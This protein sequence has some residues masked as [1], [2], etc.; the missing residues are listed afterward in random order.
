[1]RVS[2]VVSTEF[3]KLVVRQVLRQQEDVVLVDEAPD[4]EALTALS[5][6]DVLIIERGLF[7]EVR[8]RGGLVAAHHRGQVIIVGQGPSLVMP[9]GMVPGKI[10]LVPG[11]SE[12]QA[13]DP[14]LL[15]AR[16]LLALQSAGRGEAARSPRPALLD[17]PP[18]TDSPRRVRR[19]V[20][21]ALVGI[22][23]STGGPD[24]LQLLLGALDRPTCPLV[25][26][27]HIPSAHTASLCQHLAATSRHGVVVS[28]G[29]AMAR[30]G[31][32]LLEGGADYGIEAL[33]AE[34]V[35]KRLR[36]GPS[37][38][39]PNGDILFAS[40][41]G[42]GRPVVGVILSGMGD[43]GTRGAASLFAKGYPVLVQR[44]DTCVV[45]GMPTA[46]IA[47]GVASEV[48]APL[49]IARRLNLWFTL[50]ETR[51]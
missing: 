22:A 19:M 48:A 8:G 14:S 15:S 1:M 10:F 36:K 2:L 21:P 51:D 7:D 5:P 47:A 27:L 26:A 34:L 43:D 17:A 32:T 41:A 31:I 40:M 38:F 46:A 25:I 20:R 28:A 9:Q 3:L 24:V 12:G 50:P 6:V 16:L 30:Q 39:H 11:G 42:L 4:L 33:G 35:V 49:D 23:V 44:P 45:P 37:G 13:L 29:G 18:V